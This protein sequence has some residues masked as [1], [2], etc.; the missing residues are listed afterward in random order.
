M[1]RLLISLV[2]AVSLAALAVPVASAQGPIILDPWMAGTPVQ[3]V[4]YCSHCGIIG[5]GWYGQGSYPLPD[6][7][8]DY[9]AQQ[10]TPLPEGITE[11]TSYQCPN[12]GSTSAGHNVFPQGGGFVNT[13][14]TVF[15]QATYEAARQAAEAVITYMDVAAGAYGCQSAYDG[16]TWAQRQALPWNEFLRMCTKHMARTPENDTWETGC[17][18]LH[19]EGWT[20]PEGTASDGL[21]CRGGQ[22]VN[23][24]GSLPS[25]T[26][27]QAPAASSGGGC[28]SSYAVAAGYPDGKFPEGYPHSDGVRVC[29][30]G[31]WVSR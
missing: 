7:Y 9:M 20:L 2:L 19:G 22:W 25:Q 24:P 12:C 31:Q 28:P 21:V 10:G 13:G 16:L 30:G 26:P 4:G 6:G 5:E 8:A 15:D 17:P 1:R 23:V 29:R 27:A 18:A 3:G 11:M 14:V